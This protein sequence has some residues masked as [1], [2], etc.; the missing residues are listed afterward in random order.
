MHHLRSSKFFGR[1][2]TNKK[3]LPSAGERTTGLYHTNYNTGVIEV[4]AQAL[5]PQVVDEDLNN[6]L[7]LLKKYPYMK[8]LIKDYEQHAEDLRQTDIEGE[9]ARKLEGEQYSNKTANAVIYAEK[10]RLIYEE[11]KAIT[12]AIERAHRLIISDEEKRAVKYRYLQGLSYKET[13]LF[14][15]KEMS[16]RTLDRR[17][18]AGVK[19]IATTLKIWGILDRKFRY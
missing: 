1:S 5:F 8:M 6:T 12:E 10:Q 7:F 17:L 15:K 13:L 4:E 9:T 19:C 2:D 18:N 16:A 3:P 14:F 11:Y